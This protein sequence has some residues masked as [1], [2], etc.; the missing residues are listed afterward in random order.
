MA[1]IEGLSGLGVP[2]SPQQADE[3][4]AL[5]EAGARPEASTPADWHEAGRVRILLAES[6][7]AERDGL[8]KILEGAGYLVTAVSSGRLA[9]EQI[10]LAPPDLVIAAVELED[11]DGYRVCEG[12]R[13]R[14]LPNALPVILVARKGADATV[15]RGMESGANDLIL[16]PF[17]ID[18]FLAR[19]QTQAE[20]A[21]TTAIYNRFVPTEFLELL[22]HRNITDVK[23][24]DQAQREMTVLF[25]DIRSFTSLSERMT[26]Q[27]NFKFINSYLSRITPF[28]REYNGIVD[29]YIGDAV[30]ALYPGKPEDAIRSAVSILDYVNV[31]NGYRAKSGYRPINVGIGI[32]TGNLILGIIGDNERLEGTVISDAVNLASRIQDVTKLYGVNIIISQDTFVRLDNPTDYNFRFLGK[33]KVKG[34]IQTVSL[35]EIFDGDNDAQRELKANTKSDFER[36]ILQ[37][38]HRSF[39]DAASSFRA[40]VSKNPEDHAASLFLNRAELL[41]KREKANWLLQ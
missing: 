21:R 1:S 10:V 9:R 19:V 3:A 6:N 35:F 27:E 8:K 33:V 30:M 16:R 41:L 14:H 28:I 25:V 11:V 15:A 5:E 24:G 34:K 17:A 12:I 29:K 13:E 20:L 2:Q 38:S 4:S 36:A 31:Y 22:G 39:E 32:H 26:P 40:I 18:E 7:P 23:L 37:F